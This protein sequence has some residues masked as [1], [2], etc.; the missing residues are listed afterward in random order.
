MTI[1][2][3]VMKC[4]DMKNDSIIRASIDVKSYLPIQDKIQLIDTV[5][6]E[7]IELWYG[8]LRFNE[9]N[10]Y[11]IFT[12]EVLS[13]YTN[14]TWSDDR[15]VRMLEYDM[16]K[17]SGLLE[18]TIGFFEAEYGVCNSL[19]NMQINY[20]LEDNKIEAQLA[21]LIESGIEKLDVVADKAQQALENLNLDELEGI[22]PA[23]IE[24]VKK[25]L[26]K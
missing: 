17:T 8:H 15:D 12:R 20:V 22:D 23:T 21:K 6:D 25:I 1:Q 16:L 19:L 18:K 24:Q 26:N 14:L 3:Y 5:I 7:S 2:E 9:I 13:A 4:K 11:L 10:R